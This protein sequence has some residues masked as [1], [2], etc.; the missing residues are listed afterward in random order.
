MITALLFPRWDACNRHI[1]RSR[2][3]ESAAEAW[4][5][6]DRDPDSEELDSGDVRA[7]RP[8]IVKKVKRA[9]A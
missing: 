1:A 8:G 9:D 4:G 7:P 2:D 6:P 5:D 3:K